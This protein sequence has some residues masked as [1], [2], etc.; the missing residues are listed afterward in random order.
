MSLFDLGGAIGAAGLM[1]TFI[2]SAVKN[3][4]TLY[5]MEKLEVRS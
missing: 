1:V 2:V 4:K 5:Q 3:G